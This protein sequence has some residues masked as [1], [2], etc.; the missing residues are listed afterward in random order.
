MPAA[1]VFE[2]DSET[3]QSL[4]SFIF[5][6]WSYEEEELCDL[7]MQMFYD[8]RIM[9]PFHIDPEMLY[10][11]LERLRQEY[12]QNPY[13]NFRHA[14][15]VTQMTY[16]FL[17]SGGAM[18]KL[19]KL[20]VLA[21]MLSAICHDI[22]H[23]GV[24]NN[25]HINISSPFALRYNDKSV[26][27]NHHAYMTFLLLSMP[28]YNITGGLSEEQA[29]SL[30]ATVIE[31]ILATDLKL[32]VDIFS[33]FQSVASRLSASET[34]ASVD[35]RRLLCQVI[36]KASDISN[37]VRPF[38]IAKQWSDM[39]VAEFYEQGDLE[40]E[41][42]VPV[43]PFMDRSVGGQVQMTLGFTDFV[44]KPLFAALASVL[45]ETQICVDSLLY[46]RSRWVLIGQE[47]AALAELKSRQAQQ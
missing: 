20:D 30:R 21:L 28:E 5:D 36:L 16:W 47:Q 12:Q 6:V 7:T 38:A 22:D 37:P 46:N 39:V 11:F 34:E 13:H 43:S 31:C 10:A 42:Q 3:V 14:F 35:E 33:R 25:F 2:H 17:T 23:P 18:R 44:V 19:H 9:Q 8:L 41:L 27:E 24:N 32:H 29:R 4:R 26:L 1:P 45:P 40:R 15:D